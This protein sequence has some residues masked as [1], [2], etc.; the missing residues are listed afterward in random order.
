MWILNIKFFP[1]FCMLEIL[2]NM[3]GNKL[4]LSCFRNFIYIYI[5]LTPKSG[6]IFFGSVTRS[7]LLT[8]S[9]ETGTLNHQQDGSFLRT[10]W[11]GNCKCS[12]RHREKEKEK[13]FK[14]RFPIKHKTWINGMWEE[15]S[16]KIHH[17]KY[18][19]NSIRA[20]AKP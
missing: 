18:S 10:L 15:K 9:V 13:S 1:I 17:S 14:M 2:Y 6:N 11:N 12:E 4:W 8:I 3:L 7:V 16:I 19:I 20:A 5:D